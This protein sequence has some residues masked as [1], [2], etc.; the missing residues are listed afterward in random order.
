MRGSQEEITITHQDK[1]VLTAR[2]L[3]GL[4]R[5]S[6]ACEA[7]ACISEVQYW[8]EAL[9]HSSPQT[10]NSSL[11]RYQ[12][13]QLIPKRP[14][15][16]HCESC[17]KANSRNMAPPTINA[18]RR[19]PEPF[20]LIHCDLAGPYPVQSLGGA[21]YDLIIVDDCT[22]FPEIQFLKHKSDTMKHLIQFCERVK[23]QTGRY[24]REFRTDRGGEF[25]SNEWKEFC[26]SKG[27]LLSTSPAHSP[28]SNGIA[29]RFNLTIGDMTRVALMNAPTYLWAEAHNWATY[30][31][32]R[33]PHTA[34]DGKTPMKC[35]TKRNPLLDTCAP[36][37][38]NALSIFQRMQEVLAAS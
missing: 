34:L 30:L 11:K 22:R 20:D 17:M 33:L 37:I 38:Q 15:I 19:K 32:Q 2:K 21:L 27:I 1:H 5:V 16:F 7:A 29:E 26:N 10:W 14:P 18:D 6:T 35:C 4:Y 3:N 13:G 31:R 36:S 12:D 28:Q 23:N 24:P 25:V 9:G 8:H